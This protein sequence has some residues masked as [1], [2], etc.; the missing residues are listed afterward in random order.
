M[1]LD[2]SLAAVEVTLDTASLHRSRAA[3]QCDGG[4]RLRRATR[5][6]IGT[7]K[8]HCVGDAQGFVKFRYGLQRYV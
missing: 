7:V 2:E 8:K 1:K 6:L 5:W 3:R 4:H